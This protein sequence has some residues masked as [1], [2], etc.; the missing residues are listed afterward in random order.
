MEERAVNSGSTGE[1]NPCTS[2]WG[3]KTA[4]AHALSDGALTVVIG[5]SDEG[6]MEVVIIYTFGNVDVLSHYIFSKIILKFVT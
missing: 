3:K 1:V 2:I 4:H 5:L 6:E